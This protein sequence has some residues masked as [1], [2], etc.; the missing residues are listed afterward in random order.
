M[1]IP[2]DDETKNTEALLFSPISF[3][4]RLNTASYSL[5]YHLS[6]VFFKVNKNI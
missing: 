6:N 5:L 4:A 1:P 2:Y 3:V